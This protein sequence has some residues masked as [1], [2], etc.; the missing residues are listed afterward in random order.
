MANQVS[1][2]QYCKVCALCTVAAG[3]VLPDYTV[4]YGNN[5][6]RTE[7]PGLEAARAALHDREVEVLRKLIPSNLAKWQS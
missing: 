5:E 1:P 7:K 2:C 4:I 3:E 6:R